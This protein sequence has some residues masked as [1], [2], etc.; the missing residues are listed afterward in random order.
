M[1]AGYGD[2]VGKVRL[3]PQSSADDGEFFSFGAEK[4]AEMIDLH[5]YSRIY[6]V[7]G[8]YEYV[9]QDLLQCRSPLVAADAVKAVV[10]EVGLRASQLCVLDL[11]AGTG[12]LGQLLREAGVRSI[13]A[14]DSL[15][16]AR[17]AALRDRPGVY[18]E[19]VVGDL[20]RDGSAVVEELSKRFLNCL[21]SAGA[22]GG[23]HLGVRGLVRALSLLVT[24]SL[25]VLTIRSDMLTQAHHEGFGRLVSK[26]RE[27][28]LLEVVHESSFRHRITT[29]GRPINYVVLAAR[30]RAPVPSDLLDRAPDVLS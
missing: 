1:N 8:L 23:G 7:P 19:Y 4:S 18:D 6:R 11:G 2:L 30:L 10:N 22:L 13:V 21:V 14:I 28:D 17:L 27:L 24:E 5:D 29:S 12:I 26:L 16:A 20:E 3:L 25:V 9:V 15:L